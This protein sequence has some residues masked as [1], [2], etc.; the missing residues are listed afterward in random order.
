MIAP[1]KSVQPQFV[2]SLLSTYLVA[3]AAMTLFAGD[4]GEALAFGAGVWAI[5]ALIAFASR[6]KDTLFG[7]F[8]PSLLCLAAIAVLIW[9]AGLAF[10]MT[11]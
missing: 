9:A 11:Y 1:Q 10:V 6:K 7:R 8:G 4:L 2:A 5:P 3:V